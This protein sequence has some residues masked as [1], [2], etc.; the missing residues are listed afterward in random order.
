MIQEIFSKHHASNG[1]LLAHAASMG[2]SLSGVLGAYGGR[3]IPTLAFWAYIAL[4]AAC[5]GIPAASFTGLFLCACQAAGRRYIPAI[6][7]RSGLALAVAAFSSAGY[8]M[9]DY[10]HTFWGDTPMQSEWD[11]PMAMQ[12]LALMVPLTMGP[13]ADAF[14]LPVALAVLAYGGYCL[15][16]RSHG[17]PLFAIQNRVLMTK[18]SDAKLPLDLLRKF[19]LS[20]HSGAGSSTHVFMHS[21]PP[22]VLRA[23][24]QTARSEAI[25]SMFWAMFSEDDYDIKFIPEMSELYVTSDG[26]PGTVDSDAVFLREHVDGPF[27]FVP[28]ASVYRTLISL[29]DSG[30][31]RT[32]FPSMGHECAPVLRRGDVCAFD[33]NR[34]PHWISRTPE[35]GGLPRVLIKAHYLVCPKGMPTLGRMLRTAN[36]LYN[37]AF[38]RLFLATKGTT[39]ILGAAV[40]AGTDAFVFFHK[41]VGFANAFWLA[42][43]WSIGGPLAVLSTQLVHPVRYISTFDWRVNVDFGV[44]KRDALLFKTAAFTRLFWLAFVQAKDRGIPTAPGVLVLAGGV[45]S[46]VAFRA[47]GVDRTYFGVELGAIRPTARIS[48]FPYNLGI[49]HCM[50]LGH[51]A[52]AFGLRLWIGAGFGFF[53][54]YVLL[55]VAH[56]VQEELGLCGVWKAVIPLKRI[57]SDNLSYIY[58]MSWE[59]GDRDTELYGYGEETN[60]LMITTG[61]DNVLN[62]LA[63]DCN[64]VFS[65]DANACQTYLFDMKVAIVR[66]CTQQDAFAILGSSDYGLFCDRWPLIWR[67]LSA[68]GSAAWWHL[69]RQLATSFIDSG[70]ACL[71]HILMRVMTRALG[72]SSVVRRM[73]A[74]NGVEDQRRLYREHRTRISIAGTLITMCMGILAN[75]SGVPSKQLFLSNWYG[76]DGHIL[77]ER[78]LRTVQLRTN[79]FYQAVLLGRW[80]PFACPKYLRPEHFS[81]VKGRL[82]RVT[83]VTASLS[84]VPR[85]LSESGRVTKFDVYNGLDHWDWME[86]SD[87][88]AEI[89]GLLPH[90]AE[91][92]R[93]VWRSAASN[94]NVA[95]LSQ[96]TFLRSGP[97]FDRGEET[98]LWDRVA[99]YNSLHVAIAPASGGWELGVLNADI[100]DPSTGG[101]S[102]IEETRVFVAMLTSPLVNFNL[103]GTAFLDGFYRNQA[104]SYDAYRKNM[105][106]G[107]RVLMRAMPWTSILAEGC[108]PNLMVMCG[109]TGDVLDYLRPALHRFGRLVVS[110]VCT[111]LL[112]QA[113]KRLRTL[114]VPD[115]RGQTEP[116]VATAWLED[117]NCEEHFRVEEAG[118]FDVVVLTYS[119]TM[120]PDWKMAVDRAFAYLKVGGMLAVSDFTKGTR[121]QQGFLSR[122]LL[123]SCLGTCHVHTHEGHLQYM[124]EKAS[125]TVFS[126]HGVGGFGNVPGFVQSPFYVACFRK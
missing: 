8:A 105:L 1:I 41:N 45:L 89:R 53:G 42:A 124:G 97:T 19:V 108:R 31:F 47:L 58:P 65:V 98:E 34:E 43:A 23:A 117:V 83:A 16:S 57:M 119:L 22:E 28:F 2:I 74:C 21:L 91:G 36:V 100:Q 95:V 88:V 69:N 44:F 111:P 51:L 112:D 20:M 25:L 86:E 59:D 107:K 66:S 54:T 7:S 123:N 52:M 118:A 101:L 26:E 15:S 70:T 39:S 29:D 56:T 73:A 49:P 90:L 46:A 24:E 103:R 87:I 75:C 61:G 125:A 32:H 40:V 76:F 104:E 72:I 96:L 27:G 14:M 84:D 50:M 92:C 85:I 9:Q 11:L 37:Y 93:M 33:F 116:L 6:K 122:T 62:A 78:M 63:D 38:R 5:L 81:G 67:N 68:E 4:S 60:L 110:D 17:H 109:G 35:P 71:P 12:H 113:R 121:S 106:H 99:S 126:T 64:S 82:H 102:R 13:L 77:L 55:L 120:V 10:S 18:L 115:P 114:D 30:T 3:G 80:L 79:P 48:C 94:Q